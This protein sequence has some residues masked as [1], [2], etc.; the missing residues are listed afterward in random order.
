MTYATRRW[1]GPLKKA[2]IIEN[3]DPTLDDALRALG[4]EPQRLNEPPDEDDLVRILSEGQHN[5]IYKRSQVEISER[6]VLASPN[7]AAVMLCCIGDDSVDKTACA[8]HGVMVMNDPVSNGP[9]R[10]RTRHRRNPRPFPPPLRLRR[11]DE[12]VPLAQEQQ[13]SLRG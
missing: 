4:I 9:L 12:Q 11:R 2:L 5:L 8:K 1:Q 3:P 6:V 10:R 7:L 13:R